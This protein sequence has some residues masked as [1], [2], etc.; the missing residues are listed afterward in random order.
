MVVRHPLLVRCR[1]GKSRQ[2]LHTHT[3][4]CAHASLHPPPLD[5]P[6]TPAQG[7]IIKPWHTQSKGKLLYHWYSIPTRIPSSIRSTP[8]RS[9]NLSN[10]TLLALLFC[11]TQK[12]LIL[13]IP[14]NPELQDGITY[15]RSTLIVAA[16]SSQNSFIY[17]YST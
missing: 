13:Y 15:H 1:R 10:I 12:K 11:R 9:L 16:P 5:L 2:S 4:A 3:P 17:S 6:Y 7:P 8:K 14:K